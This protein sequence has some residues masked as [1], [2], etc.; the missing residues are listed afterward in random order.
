MVTST[1][2]PHHN[3]A[4]HAPVSTPILRLKGIVSRVWGGLQY[5]WFGWIELK[6]KLFRINFIFKSNVV[7]TLNFQ[8]MAP[9]RLQ[10]NPGFLQEQDFPGSNLIIADHVGNKPFFRR[11]NCSSMVLE[12]CRSS[13][14]WTLNSAGAASAEKALWRGVPPEF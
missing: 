1:A 4:P 13:P 10:Y 2:E 9:S 14:L 8:K 3:D 6:F 5:W 7:F 12:L 11:A